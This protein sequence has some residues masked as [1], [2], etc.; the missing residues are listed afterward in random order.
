MLRNYY[1]RQLNYFEQYRYGA[2]ALMLTFQSCWGA[3]AAMFTL[4]TD[5]VPGLAICAVLTMIC[6][7]TFIAIAPPK[8]CVNI[9]YLSVLVNSFIIFYGILQ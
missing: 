4:R 5:N 8:W 2:S 7:A 3:I 1:N 9:F 6:N